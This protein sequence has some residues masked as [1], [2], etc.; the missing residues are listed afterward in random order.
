MDKEK[1]NSFVEGFPCSSRLN[2]NGFLS[3][4]ALQSQNTNVL[5]DNTQIQFQDSSFC[6]LNRLA[7][8]LLL[9]YS[10]S[11]MYSH[12]ANRSE[13]K[14]IRKLLAN[15]A[16]VRCSIINTVGTMGRLS[17]LESFLISLFIIIYM[18]VTYTA[19]RVKVEQFGDNECAVA[20]IQAHA[21]V[22]SP[23]IL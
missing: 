15:R 20:L 17:C 22:L 13:Q 2:Y 3:V 7:S 8:F 11:A 4:S 5:I 9:H 10:S 21:K 6:N 23:F 19:R 14:V 1:A 18:N 12:A 16:S